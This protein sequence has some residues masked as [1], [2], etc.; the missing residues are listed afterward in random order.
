MP[1][2][3]A[4]LTSVRT[5]AAAAAASAPRPPDGS[6]PRA[7]APPKYLIYAD[8]ASQPADRIVEYAGAHV[9]K[10][11]YRVV[12]GPLEPRDVRVLQNL[13]DDPRDRLR[14]CRDAPQVLSPAEIRAVETGDLTVLANKL[15]GEPGL[16]LLARPIVSCPLAGTIVIGWSQAEVEAIFKDDGWDAMSSRGDLSSSMNKSSPKLAGSGQG[17][18]ASVRAAKSPLA[19]SSI[20]ADKHASFIISVA[21][22][23]VSSGPASASAASAPPRS[24]GTAQV[25]TIAMTQ[26]PQFPRSVSFINA[27][28][29]HVDGGGIHPSPSGTPTLTAGGGDS[30]IGNSDGRSSTQAPSIAPSTRKSQLSA[31]LGRHASYVPKQHHG[32]DRYTL[33][34]DPA[35]KAS[36]SVIE[37][38]KDLLS[39]DEYRINLGPLERREVVMLQT[40]IDP[41]ERYRLCS[42]SKAVIPQDALDRIDRG[43]TDVLADLLAGPAGLARLARPLLVCWVT[44]T[45]VVGNHVDEVRSMLREHGWDAEIQSAHDNA[46]IHSVARS[47][48][49]SVSSIH[50]ASH[51]AQHSSQH[52]A[53]RAKFTLYHDPEDQDSIAVYEILATKL[54]AGTFRVITGPLD[55]REIKAIQ[56]NLDAS[57]RLGLCRAPESL[58]TPAEIQRVKQDDLEVLSGKLAGPEGSAHL[59]RPLLAC[60]VAG[61]LVI[62]NKQADIQQMIGEDGWNSASVSTVNL[63]VQRTASQTLAELRK[64][65]L[66]S[67]GTVRGRTGVSSSLS[68]LPGSTGAQAGGHTSGQRGSATNSARASAHN[69]G[70]SKAKYTVYHNPDDPKSNEMLGLLRERASAAEITVVTGPLTAKEIKPLLHLLEPKHYTTLLARHEALSADDLAKVRAGKTDA[71]IAALSSDAGLA[72]M[73]RPII[74]CPLLGAILVGHK[75]S[76]IEEVLGDEAW[77]TGSGFGMDAG[78]TGGSDAHPP[79]SSA[80]ARTTAAVPSN[81]A[82]PHALPPSAAVGASHGSSRESSSS[83]QGISGTTTSAPA[84]TQIKYLLYHDPRDQKSLEVYRLL[85]SSAEPREYS[86]FSSTSLEPRDIRKIQH[87]LEPVD[88]LQLCRSTVGLL[89]TSEIERIVRNGDVDIL[90]RK[91]SGEAGAKYLFRPILCCPIAGHAIVGAKMQEIAELLHGGN[92]GW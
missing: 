11:K 12:S 50:S 92:M 58:L 62:G 8:N 71:L 52:A 24:P 46:S 18:P 26:T 39:A 38:V 79:K 27:S 56:N 70:A 21:T 84:P 4:R 80:G 78:A 42:D 81:T 47:D 77:G 19:A 65:V 34:A 37:I 87:L 76:Q 68:S 31:R 48:H 67:R 1:A 41:A 72:N 85:E 36:A 9:D 17:T 35:E 22:A 59:M 16:A 5:A 51:A 82:A 2:D 15:S 23:G 66:Q 10:A 73:A 44:G 30:A 63:N 88:R 33:F 61:T 49:H 90:A 54:A 89:D 40:L 53:A 91:L 3:L 20:V 14:L 57:E 6:V 75:P 55:K 83:K 29:R 86:V 13:L 43:D 25:A 60:P 7:D 64:T 45:V 32:Q 28:V 74:V 69:I